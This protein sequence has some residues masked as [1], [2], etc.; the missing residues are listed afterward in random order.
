MRREIINLI[1]EFLF[2]IFKLIN[3][4]YDFTHEKNYQTSIALISCDKWQKKVKEDW[5]LKNEL[6]KLNAKVDIVSWQD[7]SIDFTKYDSLIIRSIWGFQNYKEEFDK[8]LDIIDTQKIKIF[9][10]ID[11]IRNNYNKEL[12]FK[13]LKKYGIKTIKTEF[14]TI[15]QNLSQKIAIIQKEKPIVVKPSVSESGNDTYIIDKSNST[16]KNAICLDKINDIFNERYYGKKLMIQPFVNEVFDGEYSICCI[17][18][19]ITHA[20]LKYSN[21]FENK[22]IIKNIPLDDIDT[23]MLEITKNILNIKEY[24]DNLYMRVDFLKQNNEYL[25]MEVELLDPNMFLLFISEKKKRL[26]TCR[27]F[28][29]AILKRTTDKKR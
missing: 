18:G 11:I 6:N 3:K 28:A 17:N 26:K 22:N 21:V 19:V 23:N 27:D 2:R 7:K 25:I 5:Y 12:Q 14:I 13:L 1:K 15:D 29:K 4:F 24:K 10:N 20:V 16:Y 8:W 9:N